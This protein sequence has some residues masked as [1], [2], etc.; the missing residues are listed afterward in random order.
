MEFG[1]SVGNLVDRLGLRLAVDIRVVVVFSC[2][3][4]AARFVVVVL[5]EGLLDCGLSL[6]F[7]LLGFGG[8]CHFVG[9]GVLVS[10]AIA[11]LVQFLSC[12]VP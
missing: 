12:T 5:V 7:D 6:G 8:K 9:V 2:T 1:S 3:Y 11:L 4:F 10:Q